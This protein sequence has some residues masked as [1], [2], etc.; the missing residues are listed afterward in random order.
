MKYL[1]FLAIAV[2]TNFYFHDNF[3]YQ[4]YTRHYGF[5]IV[6]ALLAFFVLRHV[7]QSKNI[8]QLIYLAIALSTYFYI[9]DEYWYYR[10]IGRYEFSIILALLTFFVLV[11]IYQKRKRR[12]YLSTEQRGRKDS[13]LDFFGENAQLITDVNEGTIR[14]FKNK[15][16]FILPMD[17]FSYRAIEQEHS[18]SGRTMVTG[19]YYEYTVPNGK[20]EIVVERS[21]DKNW[22][23]FVEDK[24]DWKEFQKVAARIGEAARPIRARKEK[25]AAERKELEARQA[26]EK[27]EK[28]KREKE[29]VKRLLQERVSHFANQFVN[30]CGIHGDNVLAGNYTHSDDGTLMTAIAAGKDGRGGMI[31]NRGN[32]KWIGSWKGAKVEVSGNN[33]EILVDDP[34]YR[35][36]NFA[37]RRVT[38]EFLN[39][40]QRMMWF[41]RINILSKG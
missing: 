36:K 34:E 26:A 5:F 32:L 17:E 21:K 27:L 23:S 41:D 11:N 16:E 9:R 30:E 38:M 18:V 35:A 8:K 1:I 40:E 29:E 7:Y 39:K 19:D 12:K 13:K 4:F 25:E 31:Y 28:E 22:I 2:A 14:V 33:L 10:Y 15:Q 3:W 37:E 24:K 20:Y 6:F